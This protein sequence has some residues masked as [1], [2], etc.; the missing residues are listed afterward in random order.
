MSKSINSK[1]FIALLCC[2]CS[3]LFVVQPTSASKQNSDQL[4]QEQSIQQQQDNSLLSQ[5]NERVDKS[6]L[7]A[8]DIYWP[9]VVKQKQAPAVE[10]LQTLKDYELS[11]QQ[12]A[13]NAAQWQQQQQQATFGYE[14]EKRRQ[15]NELSQFMHLQPASVLT[16]ALDF[17]SPGSLVAEPRNYRA[18]VGDFKHWHLSNPSRQGRAFKPRIMSTARGFGKRSLQV[19]HNNQQPQLAAS[20]SAA[21]FNDQA[22]NSI[23]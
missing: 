3:W 15:A 10:W 1:V 21:L 22:A 12:A 20:Y 19:Q 8:G 16:G 14:A 4:D 9:S 11:Q 23:R 6:A 17:E 18:L 13:E 5:S 2:C 7:A